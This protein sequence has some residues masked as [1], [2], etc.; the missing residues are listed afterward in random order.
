MLWQVAVVM[1][2]ASGAMVEPLRADFQ[3]AAPLQRARVAPLFGIQGL[4]GL[5]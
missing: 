4:R 2:Q 3:T 5:S 1:P